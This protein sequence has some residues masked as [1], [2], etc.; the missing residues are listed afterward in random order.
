[1]AATEARA[2]PYEDLPPD[3][4]QRAQRLHSAIMCAQCAGQSLDQ[5]NAP[6]A[7]TMRQ[8][9]REQLIAGDDDDEIIALMVSAY[10]EGI[11]ASPPARGF[12]LAAWVVPPIAILL[13]AV[14]VAF[15]VRSL[16]RK[17]QAAGHDAAGAPSGLE[18]Y[19]DIV[20]RELAGEAASGRPGASG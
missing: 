14:A 3:L 1:M 12:S 9:I 17:P 16:R 10:G 11:L 18:P 20:D 6:L 4:E 5:S 8:T 19:L 13:G 15:A 7:K 2:Q